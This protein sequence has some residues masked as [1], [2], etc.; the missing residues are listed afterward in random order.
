[1][2]SVIVLVARILLAVIFILA[3]FGKLT[4]ISG[5]AAYFGMYRSAGGLPQLALA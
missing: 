1:M 2:N 5:T 3:G 4:D